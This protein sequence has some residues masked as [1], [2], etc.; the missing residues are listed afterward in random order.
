VTIG[1]EGFFG[2]A[3]PYAGAN[4]GGAGGWSSAT[5]QARAPLPRSPLQAGQCALMHARGASMLSMRPI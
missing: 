2:P 3:S 5:G 4:P 1:E